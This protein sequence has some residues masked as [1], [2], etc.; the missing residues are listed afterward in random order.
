MLVKQVKG[1]ELKESNAGERLL[2]NNGCLWRACFVIDAFVSLFSSQMCKETDLESRLDPDLRTQVKRKWDVSRVLLMSVL[3]LML[4]TLQRSARKD[5]RRH[6]GENLDVESQNLLRVQHKLISLLLRERERPF[7]S[8]FFSL[9][10]AHW[11]G[12]LGYGSRNFVKL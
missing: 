8:V 6:K 11:L 10:Q 5:W 4:P 9:K 1:L 12:E 7:R 2:L 3:L